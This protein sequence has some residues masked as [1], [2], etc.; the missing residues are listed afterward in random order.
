MIDLGEVKVGVMWHAIVPRMAREFTVIAPDLRGFGDISKPASTP[1]HLLCSN[2]GWRRTRSFCY[3]TSASSNFLWQGTTGADAMPMACCSIIPTG[4][5]F[6]RADMKFG[7][8]YWHWFFLAQT[9]TISTSAADGNNSIPRR[10]PITWAAAITINS[11]KPTP[12][13]SASN[14]LCSCCA[15]VSERS[16]SGM[17]CCPSGVTGWQC[18]EESDRRTITLPNRRRMRPAKHCT[19][20]S[21]SEY[22][23]V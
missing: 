9:P 6:R 17:M 11:M 21:E 22:E 18:A 23:S 1:D 15:A 20:S 12:A 19:N 3:N 4:E 14:A 10:S 13:R 2:E 7:L 16:Q 8:G 5:A